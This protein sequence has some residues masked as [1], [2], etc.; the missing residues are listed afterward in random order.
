MSKNH[1]IKCSL[2]YFERLQKEEKLYEVRKNDRDY[3]TRDTLTIT[4]VS[5]KNPKK[6][7]DYYDPLEFRVTHV[8]QESP[9]L[10][11]G[12]CVLGIE[13]THIRTIRGK[14]LEFN[15]YNWEGVARDAHNKA[16]HEYRNRVQLEKEVKDLK[17]Q[18]EL[19]LKDPS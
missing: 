18:L 6:I 19:A 10:K 11:E 2:R 9:G 17:R 3:Q 14:D 7:V 8:L 4:A 13:P 15:G 16:E 12:Y 5:D 1:N